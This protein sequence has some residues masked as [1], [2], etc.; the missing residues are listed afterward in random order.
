MI[1]AGTVIA[2]VVSAGLALI[3]LLFFRTPH[4]AA[5]GYGVPA[6]PDGNAGAYLSVKGNRDLAIALMLAVPLL[7][8]AHAV[9]GGMLIAGSVA[10]FSDGIIVLRHHGPKITAYAVHI[11]TGVLCVLGG[12]LLLLG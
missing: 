8:G 9:A 11:G 12:L 5:A 3:A 4:S 10:A 7:V 1:I 2:A 6:T